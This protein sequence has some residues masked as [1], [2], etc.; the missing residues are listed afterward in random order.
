MAFVDVPVTGE[1][2]D[3]IGESSVFCSEYVPDDWSV[4]GWG[5]QEGCIA[6]YN[7]STVSYGSCGVQHDL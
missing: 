2:Y 3:L 1:F 5:T 6:E 4:L 7:S